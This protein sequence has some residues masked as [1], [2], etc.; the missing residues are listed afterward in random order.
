V[1]AARQP[2]CGKFLRASTTTSIW[3][4]IARTQGND[5]VYG[6]SVEDWIIRRREPK[7][8]MIGYGSVSETAK[9]SVFYEGLINL[10]MLKV[11]SDLIGNYKELSPGEGLLTRTKHILYH[12]CDVK[13]FNFE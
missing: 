3:K 7:S 10:R 9:V 13:R 1:A 5:L 6:N 8:V 11:Q 12:E 4:H 2:G